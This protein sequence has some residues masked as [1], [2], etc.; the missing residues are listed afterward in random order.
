VAFAVEG[1]AVRQDGVDL[2][3]LAVGRALHPEL[4]LLGI[5]AGGLTRH[6][7]SE[8][9]PGQARLLCFDGP[10]AGD[11]DAEVVEAAAMTRLFQ[12]HQLQR[13]VGDGEVGIPR[14]ALGRVGAEQRGVEGDGLVHVGDVERELKTGH[15]RNLRNK[16]SI[17]V[18]V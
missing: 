16:T 5:A 13:R 3:F 17:T 12:Q 9:G 1:G 7:R 11:L 8:P 18:Y 15:V 6:A 14:A 4:V 2:P 10:G